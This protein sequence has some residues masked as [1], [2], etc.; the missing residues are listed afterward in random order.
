MKGDK[1]MRSKRL[2]PKDNFDRGVAEGEAIGEAK[3]N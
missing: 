2:N 1:T 3:T